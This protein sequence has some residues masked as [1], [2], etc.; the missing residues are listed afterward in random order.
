MHCGAQKKCGRLAQGSTHGP[1]W[2]AGA[3]RWQ[4]MHWAVCAAV[5]RGARDHAGTAGAPLAALHGQVAPTPPGLST[6]TPATSSLS[7]GLLPSPREGPRAAAART[8]GSRTTAAGR[9]RSGRAAAAG[10]KATTGAGTRPATAQGATKSNSQCAGP[11]YAGRGLR[12]APGARLPMVSGDAPRGRHVLRERPHGAWRARD[13]PT[14]EW[15]PVLVAPRDARA[16]AG[17]KAGGCSGHAGLAGD[18]L[19]RP[20][21]RA[22]STSRSGGMRRCLVTSGAGGRPAAVTPPM[23]AAPA[24]DRAPQ[25][26]RVPWAAQRGRRRD[27]GRNADGRRPS[28]GAPE[29]APQGRGGAA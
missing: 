25:P 6:P 23:P 15:G 1:L 9:A 13:L 24:G 8:A 3:P 7:T 16:G 17:G 28:Q 21:R 20:R 29:K 19:R 4:A 12:A 18:G 11:V 14:C 10:A 2:I 26:R 5:L 22:H 27:G